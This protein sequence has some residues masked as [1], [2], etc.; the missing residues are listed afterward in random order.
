MRKDLL[1]LTPEA[2]A[3]LANL[4]LVKRALREIES[5]QGPSLEETEDGVVTGT[6]PDGAMARLPLDVPLRD[7]P[8]TC[9]ATSVCRHRVAVALA[10]RNWRDA[11]SE[12][13]AHDSS[14]SPGEF[15]DADLK[16]AL[17]KRS[18]DRASSLR[19]LGC[20][21][22][23]RREE[24]R[25]P[26]ARLPTSTVAFLVPRDLAYAR[27][28]CAAGAPCEHVALAVW[29]FREAR[30][31]LQTVHLA[32]LEA[33]EVPDDPLAELV[34]FCRE[35][36]LEGVVNLPTA[37]AGR[38]A[39][40]R[41]SIDAAGMTWPGTILDDLEEA[42]EAYRLRSAR[43]TPAFP[44]R[45]LGEVAARACAVRQNGELPARYV[46]G[47]GESRE[48]P[49]GH[50]RLVGLGARVDGSGRE[51]WA[52]VFLA[53]PD[54]GV[55]L[56]LKKSWSFPEGDDPQ[57]GPGLAERSVVTG[58]RLR[59]MA[60]GQMVTRAAKR[61][62]N[63]ALR[64]SAAR[65]GTIS[66][67]PQSGDWDE[68][69]EGLVVRDLSRHAETLRARP[70]RFLRPR[71]LAE[72][73]HVVPLS[74]VSSMVYSPGR[75]ALL[76][77]VADRAGFPLRVVARHRAIAPHAIDL[78]A[79]AL[80]DARPPRF[81]SGYLFPGEQGLEMTPLAVVTDRVV[82][83]DLEATGNRVELP[84]GDS[85]LDASPIDAALAET[86]TCL[87]EAAHSGLLRPAPGWVERARAAEERLER[88]GLQQVST[89]LRALIDAVGAAAL[90]R[91][92]SSAEA[93]RAA[94]AWERVF[95]R[96]ALTREAL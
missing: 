95:V 5:G 11:S 85:A 54:A 65:R 91:G 37:I 41:A 29:A 7:A 94:S 26:E 35:V 6:F 90:A 72:S 53:D 31:S 81:L 56:V 39:R 84:L 64:F 16:A 66:V 46:L 83:L 47:V 2:V 77:V 36:I 23:V 24:G 78:L 80:G 44:A 3:A 40:V 73:F 25:H 57:N 21:V 8:C 9:G 49:V 88:V 74:A 63:R 17:G 93:A 86:S 87:E 13:P 50:L 76:A 48:T 79:G 10:Y 45:L 52:E 71:V 20:D 34:G 96:I 58:V 15:S 51:R 42:L 4:G 18:F 14:W 22:D 59:Q 28:D 82:V 92:P 62:A 1:A 27:C 38:L 55:V 60:C 61:G 89:G 43:Y 68:L 12:S 75:Q 70:P 69:P 30:S 67:T 33:R 32:P 19:K